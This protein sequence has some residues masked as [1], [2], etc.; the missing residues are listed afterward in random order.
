MLKAMVIRNLKLYFRDK[1]AVFFSLLGVL[2][3]ILLYVLFLGKM[4]A[5][6][7]EGFSDA[8]ARFFT[9]SWVMAGVIASATMTTCLGGFGIMVEDKAKNISKD[10]ESS[11]IP[12]S[13]LV[14]AYIISSVVIGLIM[15]VFTFLLGELYIVM[16]GGEFLSLHGL[17][18]ALGIIV[19]SVG[20]SSAIVF[21][22]VTFIK[23]MN[24]FSNLS[25]LIGT[26]IGFLTGVY[27][28][29]G[30]LPVFIQNVIKIFPISHGAAA[31]RQVMVQEAISLEHIPADIKAFMGIE[32]EVG[33]NIMPFWLYLAI[34]FGTLVVFYF[35][36]V[37][38]VSKCR[39][40]S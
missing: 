4:I 21:L 5:Q 28:P 40:R 23:S 8:V 32:F 13:K 38:V 16:L 6:T 31:L 27:V 9:D 22:L 34:L 1:A 37:L 3:I 18:K 30:N 10:F 7:A 15:S 14:L 20:A 36:S 2:I 35:L 26:L 29:I 24:A 17:L 11:P 19:L 25:I 12:R 33:G 39:V